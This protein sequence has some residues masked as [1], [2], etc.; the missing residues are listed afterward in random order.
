MQNANSPG[1]S[2]TI[3][4]GK[5]GY[6][7]TTVNLIGSLNGDLVDI[8]VGCTNIP[9]KF[10][11]T[12]SLPS[13]FNGRFGHIFYNMEAV[14][15]LAELS[16][17]KVLRP[18]FVQN[19]FNL[20]SEP[21]LKLPI[22]SETIKEFMSLCCKK[23]RFYISAYIPYTGYTS[24]QSIK[25]CIK[26]TNDSSVNIER[27]IISIRKIVSYNVKEV[28]KEDVETIVT[29]NVEGVESNGTKNIEYNLKIPETIT[30]INQRNSTIIQVDYDLIVSC[31][32][33]GCHFS[34]K[35]KIPIKIG[36][37]PLNFDKIKVSTKDFTIVPEDYPD[38]G[39]TLITI[40]NYNCN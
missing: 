1:C 18:F 35:L 25:V 21:Q 30:N 13:S 6:L 14:L 10:T 28:C 9:F 19:L 24:A 34:P 36:N 37:I 11:L 4:K 17:Q 8:P 22:E 31:I 32:P 27:T 12:P 39:N 5:E 38:I 15:D 2:S 40:K 3:Y 16:S 26:L 23:S 7:N 20:N 33:I 29:N